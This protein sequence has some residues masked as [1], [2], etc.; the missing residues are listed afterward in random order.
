MWRGGGGVSGCPKQ[1]AA[2]VVCVR[3]FAE[4]TLLY[5][6]KLAVHA[7]QAFPVVEAITLLHC[8]LFSSALWSACTVGVRLCL[9]YRQ[10]GRQADRQT[11]RQ[12][13]QAGQDVK[14]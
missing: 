1:I 2:S 4:Q 11:G 12:A 9:H 13:G 5:E 10:T 3:A 8:G 7:L 6:A 14:S